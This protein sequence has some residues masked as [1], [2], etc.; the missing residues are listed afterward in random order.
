MQILTTSHQIEHGDPNGRALSMGTPMEEL[1]EGLKE[2]K[3]I[4]T[5]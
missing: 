1:R 5:P 3:G 4:A 2:M